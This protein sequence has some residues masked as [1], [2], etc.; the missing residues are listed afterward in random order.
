MYLC[1]PDECESFS[2]VFG[3]HHLLQEISVL[4]AAKCC[5]MS[6]SCSLAVSIC[7]WAARVQR[8]FTAFLWK[9]CY[10][11]RE[12]ESTENSVVVGCK[13]QKNELKEAK[14]LS[15]D[16][17]VGDNLCPFILHVII[18][19]TVNMKL[20]DDFF[21]IQFRKDPNQVKKLNGP[22]FTSCPPLLLLLLLQTPCL[23]ISPSNAL[24]SHCDGWK[25]EGGR[26]RRTL[27]PPGSGFPPPPPFPA[28]TLQPRL[29]PCPLSPSPCPFLALSHYYVL[30]LTRPALQIGFAQEWQQRER[31]R[32]DVT[33]P[34]PSVATPGSNNRILSENRR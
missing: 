34:L 19:S 4:L 28:T 15:K 29:T 31:K 24:V 2:L 22:H 8:L 27:V 18:W 14:M 26:R 5:T 21:E 12:S 1:P 16:C 17:K 32:E 7:C 13:N 10:E 20:W 25:D 6:T 11:S 33:A 23:Y 3:F 9:W 30:I